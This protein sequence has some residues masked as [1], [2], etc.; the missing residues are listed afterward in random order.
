MDLGT[1]RDTLVKPFYR[2]REVSDAQILTFINI[3]KLVIQRDFGLSFALGREDLTYASTAGEGVS[4][5]NNFKA[6]YSDMSV[7]LVS[8]TGVKMPISGSSFQAEQRRIPFDQSST[9][10]QVYP[11][12]ASNVTITKSLCRYYALPI[13]T[14]ENAKWQLFLQ[15]EVLEIDLS[16]L[17][18]K[19]LA[20]YASLTE[21]DFLLVRGY[22]VLLW[23]TL[24]AGNRYQ[25]DDAKVEVDDKAGAIALNDLRDYCEKAV[26]SAGG[27]D[28]D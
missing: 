15:P 7:S 25:Q 24:K 22:D 8:S 4:L 9:D 28:I 16:V 2:R 27:I 5:P 21:E 19:W 18:F 12:N 3:A 17:Y 14:N 11:L 1:F 26:Y 20:P 23:Q 10:Q 6:F 13:N